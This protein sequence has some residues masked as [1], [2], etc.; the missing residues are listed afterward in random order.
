METYFSHDARSPSVFRRLEKP[1]SILLNVFLFLPGLLC[2]LC[3]LCGN[4]LLDF[5]LDLLSAPRSHA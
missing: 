4:L 3:V 5:V 1:L 2:V